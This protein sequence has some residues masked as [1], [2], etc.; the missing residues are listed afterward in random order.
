MGVGGFIETVDAVG[1]VRELMMWA[2]CGMVG[3]NLGCFWRCGDVVGN[4]AGMGFGL[5]VVVCMP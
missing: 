1:L 3:V 5:V 2:G 4:G